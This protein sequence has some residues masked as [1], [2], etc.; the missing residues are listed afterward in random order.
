MI[1]NVPI[2]ILYSYA[3]LFPLTTIREIDSAGA[4]WGRGLVDLI[5]PVMLRID[6]LNYPQKGCDL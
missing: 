6:Y 3:I 1:P 2:D 4:T 5:P